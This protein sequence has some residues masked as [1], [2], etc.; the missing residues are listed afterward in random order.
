MG[1]AGWAAVTLENNR[2]NLA[3]LFTKSASVA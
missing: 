1:A 3:M 2:Y